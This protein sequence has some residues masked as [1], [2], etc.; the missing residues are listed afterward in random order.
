MVP[1]AIS[2][3]WMLLLF[4]FRK[5]ILMN[6]FMYQLI[7]F[8]L[9]F[10]IMFFVY[11]FLLKRKMK[12]RKSSNIGEFSY[13]LHRF[14]LDVKKVDL[15]KLGWSIS[16]IN[17]FI[18]SFVSSFIMMIPT[19]MIWRLVIAFVLLFVL[20]YALYEIYGRHLQKKYKKD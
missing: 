7:W 1:R 14:R 18:I 17:A 8:F 3:L 19:S 16:F 11:S 20:I 10:F 5:G 12:K 9:V 6:E 4:Y 2:S 13:L 15:K